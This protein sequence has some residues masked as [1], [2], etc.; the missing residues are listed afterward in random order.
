MNMTSNCDVKHKAHQIEMTTICHWMKPPPRKFSAY[1][2]SP[3]L[4]LTQTRT[5]AQLHLL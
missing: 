3:Y 2:T 1:A 5:C 4:F